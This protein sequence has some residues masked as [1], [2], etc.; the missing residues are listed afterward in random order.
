MPCLVGNCP[1][2]FREEVKNVKSIQT[3]RQTDDRRSEKA[4]KQKQKKPKHDYIHFLIPMH[5][6]NISFIDK[7]SKTKIYFYF[8]IELCLSCMLINNCVKVCLVF[9]TFSHSFDR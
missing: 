2:G 6:S 1:G 4:H 7:L 9:K 3:V 8:Q 5:I